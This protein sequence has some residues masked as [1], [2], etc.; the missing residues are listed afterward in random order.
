MADTVE[1]KLFATLNRF[2]P[3][4]PDRYPLSPGMTARDLI[5]RLAIPEA[6]AKLVFINGV[7]ADPDTMLEPGQRI[8]IFPPVGGG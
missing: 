4:D 8:G 6:Q 3:A 2:L 1:I 5:R 7:K